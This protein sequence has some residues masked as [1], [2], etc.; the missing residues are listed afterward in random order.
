V[1]PST[2]L[3]PALPPQPPDPSCG[4]RWRVRAAAAPGHE[5]PEGPTTDGT[6]DPPQ[7]PLRSGQLWRIARRARGAALHV[8]LELRT[9]LA[10]QVFRRDFVYVSRLLHALQA[11]RR[12][13]GL[14]RARLDNALAA[15]RRRADA[16]QAL[17]ARIQAEVQARVEARGPAGARIAFARPTRFQ[18]TVLS[19]EAHRY[20]GLLVHADAALAQLERAWLLGIVDPATRAALAADCRRAL[21][22][23]KDLACNRRADLGDHVREINARR[24]REG[25][26]EGGG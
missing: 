13:Q 11:S 24:Q 21:H 25:A 15:L 16:V 4:A 5:R 23:Y 9:P 18:A 20:L 7:L 8:D 12:V 22:G 6:D 17:L 2:P 3:E 10:R 26:P 1:E 14:D 19:P